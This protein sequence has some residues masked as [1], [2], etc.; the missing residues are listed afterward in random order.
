ML[1]G[2]DK[3]IEF[4]NSVT[5]SPMVS[6]CIQTYNHAEYIE[7]CI[8]SVLTQKTNFPIEIIV[9]EDGSSDDTRAICQKIAE[10]YPDKIRL[11]FHDRSNVIL[12]KGKPS[13]RYNMMFNIL[14]ARG[15]YIALCEGDDYWSDPLKLQKQVDFLETN[16]D[17]VSCHH[18]QKYAIRNGD[19]FETREAP[20]KNQGYDN[21]EKSSLKDIFDNKVRVKTRTHLFRNVIDEFPDW[22]YK[23]A[24]GDVP[25]SMVLGEHG[26]FGFIDEEMAVYRQTNSGVST[27]GIQRPDYYYNHFINWVDIWDYANVYYNYKYFNVIAYKDFYKTILNKSKM[28]PVLLS[29]V[30]W[31]ILIDSQLKLT[32]RIKILYSLKSIL[33]RKFFFWVKGTK[34]T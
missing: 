10:K 33:I 24:Y 27:E 20:K 23:V 17:C 28:T 34:T 13:G 8:E 3:V 31:K 22:F 7:E 19:K 21:K 1:K 5:K 32:C 12:I 14:A 25:L 16:T 30:V 9:G 2:A 15:K 6:V 29:R 18:W 4:P 26:K 11:L